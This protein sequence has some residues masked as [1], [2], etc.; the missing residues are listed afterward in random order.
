MQTDPMPYI[1]IAGFAGFFF[2]YISGRLH[3]R[4]PPVRPRNRY[5]C[6]TRTR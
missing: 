1:L 4:Q 2:G 3:P 6:I 5:G